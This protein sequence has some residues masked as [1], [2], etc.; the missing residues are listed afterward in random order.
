M[1]D[2]E[3]EQVWSATVDHLRT[4]IDSGRLPAGSRLPAERT[5]CEQLG[6]SRGSLRQALRVLDSIG[7]VQVRPGSGTYVREKID[8]QPLRGWFSEHEQLVEKLFDLR[9]TVEPT[10]AERLA[11]DHTP[12]VLARLE[13]TVDEMD[14]AAADGDML[15]VIAADAEFHRVIAGNAGNDDVTDLLRSVLS[16]VGEERRAA[17]RLP[18]Q[19]RKAVDEH[20]AILEA[21]RRSDAAAAREITLRHLL[22]AKTYVH[23]Y[24]ARD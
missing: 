21:I 13:S 23:D 15:R 4:M 7:Y 17:L 10:L 16:L 8:E 1:A 20:R 2:D 3:R 19:I 24:T 9:T 22:D 12:R 18:G 11:L 14:Q 6:I 5:L